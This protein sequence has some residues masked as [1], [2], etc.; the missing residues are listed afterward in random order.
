MTTNPPGSSDL[1]RPFADDHAADTADSTDTSDTSDTSDVSGVTGPAQEGEAGPRLPTAEVPLEQP[2]GPAPTTAGFGAEPPSSPGG[3]FGTSGT[4]WDSA[5]GPR[6]GY[7]PPPPPR[8]ASRLQRSSSDR[9]LTGVCGGLGRQTGVDPILFRVGFVALVFAAGTGILL[10]LALAV[11]M[12]RDD[13]R[14]IWSRAGGR[15][16][17][18]S[19]DA[20]YGPDTQRETSGYRPPPAPVVPKGPRSPV[21]GVTVAI[22]LIGLGIVALGSRYGGWSLDPSVYFALAVAGV[23]A[24]L[25]VTAFG[26]WRRS[27]AGLITL[28]LILSFGLF[29]TSAV[30]SSGGFDEASFGE[31]NYRPVSTE[32]LRDSYQVLM[33]QSTLDLSD[34]EFSAEDPTTIRVDVTMGNFEI[35]VPRDTNVILNGQATFG[36]VSAF[37]D[38]NTID[39]S[40]PGSRDRPQ[41]D[42]EAELIL[43]IDV[44]FGNAEVTRVG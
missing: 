5:T 4:T 31:R 12:P 18:G 9:V 27:K 32:Q 20:G 7:Q 44:R 41:T 36:S 29:V 2:T 43:D 30:D 17:S 1:P 35:L 8:S 23:G 16:R 6:S 21:P 38:R 24:A 11:L 14:Q 10:Y 26:P 34:L 15:Q 13:G 39:G 33:G 42:D 19:E 37:G 25:L 28:G 22:L 40:Y 3:G